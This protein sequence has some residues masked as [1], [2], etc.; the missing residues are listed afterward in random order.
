[1]D[2]QRLMG[3]VQDP[4]AS[5]KAWR[6]RRDEAV[7]HQPATYIAYPDAEPLRPRKHLRISAQDAYGRWRTVDVHLEGY[8]FEYIGWVNEKG[9]NVWCQRILLGC[10]EADARLNALL[11][12]EKR[13]RGEEGQ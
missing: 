7:V 10:M 9:M 11:A 5:V 13:R 2:W 8:G 6:K 12:K 1:M 4:W 3:F